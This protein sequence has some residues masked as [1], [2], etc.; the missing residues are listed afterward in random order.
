[1]N[2]FR[3]LGLI[4]ISII[5]VVLFS[6]QIIY[7]QVGGSDV[8]TH[9][10]QLE[11][12]LAVI[13]AEID[14]QQVLLSDKQRERVSYERDVAILDAQIEKA[15]LSIRAR[16]IVIQKLGQDINGKEEVIGGLNEKLG[17]EKQSLAQLLRKTNEIDNISLVEVVMGN[18]NLSD[19]F[20]DLDSFDSIKI[21]LQ[22]SFVEIA[23]TKDMTQS[24]KRVLQGKQEE[25]FELRDIQRQQKMKIEKQEADKQAIVDATKGVEAEYQKLIKAKE[26][27]AAQIRTELFTLRGS[28]AIPFEQALE[29]ANIASAK[30]DVRPAFILGVI[31]EESNLG[32]NVG[33]GTWKIDLYQCYQ[34]IG[35]ITAAEKQ[36]AAF[37]KITS[38]LGL[39]PDT[40]PVSRKPWYGCGGA[41]G[42]AQFMPTTWALYVDRIAKATGHNPPSPWDNGDA[43][44]ASAIL[45]MDN[46]AD[47]GTAY[48]ERLAA[49]RYLAGWKNAEKSSYAFYGDDVM[50]LTAKYQ[51]L[52]DILQ[53]S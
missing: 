27:S 25:E 52:I 30:T 37:L 42:P 3:N 36:K 28:A 29:L 1:M 45:L 19:F 40:L 53:N 34:S 2:P 35:Y 39:N 50:A 44:M 13:E 22:G 26:K 33:T 23:N 20:E 18:Q 15:R 10:A 21:A 4:F 43:F 38:D 6:A 8:A 12:D 31:A 7:A 41:M 24:Q 47:K 51:K 49:L 46:G 48:S 5:F 32:E 9:R 17:R 14:A 16:D 11:S